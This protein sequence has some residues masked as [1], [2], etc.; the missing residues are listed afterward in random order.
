MVLE[1]EAAVVDDSIRRNGD[2]KPIQQWT[3]SL[4]LDELPDSMGL[5]GPNLDAVKELEELHFLPGSKPHVWPLRYVDY[6]QVL[7]DVLATVGLKEKTAFKAA[8]AQLDP[9]KRSIVLDGD[10]FDEFVIAWKRGDISD[11]TELKRLVAKYTSAPHAE[12]TQAH[13]G[14]ALPRE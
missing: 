8:V 5:T 3:P 2:L 13:S 9:R 6:R 14:S 7:D 11:R 4:S 1:K 12:P 10:G